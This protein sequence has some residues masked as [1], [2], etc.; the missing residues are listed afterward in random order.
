MRCRFLNVIIPTARGSV[1]TKNVLTLKPLIYH[2]YIIIFFNPPYTQK[3][4]PKGE[5]L[6]NHL[7]VS[8]GW[9]CSCIS[10]KIDKQCNQSR[11]YFVKIFLFKPIA[12]ISVT[13]CLLILK[14]AFDEKKTYLGDPASYQTFILLCGAVSIQ[15]LS[16]LGRGHHWNQLAAFLASTTIVS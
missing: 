9:I 1:V 7:D 12:L 10:A 3:S 2:A 4:L 14:T 11:L 8:R 5:G 6:S 15:W 13:L 16:V